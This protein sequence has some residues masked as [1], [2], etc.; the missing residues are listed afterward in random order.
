[1]Y[2]QE[3]TAPGSTTICSLYVANDIGSGVSFYEENNYSKCKSK[4]NINPQGAFL[5]ETEEHTVGK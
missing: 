1:M 4:E 2:F 3:D 5:S